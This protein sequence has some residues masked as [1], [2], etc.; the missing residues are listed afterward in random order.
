MSLLEL[1]ADSAR[2]LDA[3]GEARSSVRSGIVQNEV[4]IHEFESAADSLEDVARRYARLAA[5]CRAK[6]TELKPPEVPGVVSG[7]VD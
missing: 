5:A 1:I 6:A 7:R 4:I 2:A 3:V